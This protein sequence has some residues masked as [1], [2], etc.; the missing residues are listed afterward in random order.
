MI[1]AK[2][3]A[4]GSHQWSNCFGSIAAQVGIKDISSFAA[5]EGSAAHELADMLFNNIDID[6]LIGTSLDEYPDITI[7]Q[8]MVDYVHQYVDLVKAIG[9]V[10]RYECRVDF[11]D[12]VP[13]GF[14]TSD[15]ICIDG[16]MITI[17]D[18]KYGKGIRVDAFENTQAILYALGAWYEESLVRDITTIKMMIIQPRLDHVSEWTITLDEL[19]KWGEKLRQAAEMA[20]RD[21][22]PR[23]ASDKACQWCKAKANCPELKQFSDAATM[24]NF[25]D[26]DLIATDLLTDQQMA[27]ALQSKKLI[28]SWL[29]A[30]EAKVIAQLHDGK[31]FPGYKL[32]SGRSSR[33]WID[34]ESIVN[35]MANRFGVDTDDMFKTTLITPP[36]AEKLVG[37]R[38]SAELSKLINRQAGKPTLVLESDK[39]ES[40]QIT[41][42]DFTQLD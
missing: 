8:N 13:D 37:K 7:D 16:D 3:S 36:Q 1:H 35:E 28:L 2:L 22:A 10:Q 19:L 11:S 14:G 12:W 23:I 39:R 31:S 17:I 5:S 25:D 21:D 24:S 42:A 32:V 6:S 34:A 18:L 26:L 38:N 9:G 4:S 30:I 40:L 15:A 41:V 29:D 20:L 33:K 27:K